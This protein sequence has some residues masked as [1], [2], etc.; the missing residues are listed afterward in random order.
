MV[1]LSGDNPIRSLSWGAVF[2]GVFVAVP[3]YLALSLLGT[4]L[5][6]AAFDP[7]HS[8][9]PFSGMGTGAALW[10]A[11]SILLAITLGAFVAGRTA[12]DHPGLHG[13]LSW[14][15][16][17]LMG[18]TLLISLA[19]TIVGASASVI[20]KG[21]SVAGQ[22]LAAVAPATA[23][24]LQAGAKQAGIDLHPDHL[25]HELEKLL[26]QSGKAELD[27]KHLDAVAHDALS[28]AAA[29]ADHSAAQPQAAG[30][31]ASD[32]LERVKAAAQPMLDAADRDALVNII[33]GRTG[34]SR[35]EAEKIADN[36]ATTYAETRVKA[37]QAIQSMED[38]ARQGADVAASV[39]SKGS[40]MALLVLMLGAMVGFFGGRL[41]RRMAARTI[42]GTGML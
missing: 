10:L 21:V 40:W 15:V 3:T 42:A 19:S 11:F 24:A 33:V 30:E 27:P 31:D 41:G 6:A 32:W 26:R 14:S 36:Y 22:G 12:P 16:A 25:K 8:V 35:A 23:S 28:D 4:A 37:G 20:G 18:I 13:L 2:A 9:N 29:S 7:L 38:S 5:G 17:T 34:H 39:V 1:Q